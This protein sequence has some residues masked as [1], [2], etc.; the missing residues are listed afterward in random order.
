MQLKEEDAINE[1]EQTEVFNNA[2]NETWISGDNDDN[3]TDKED[4]DLNNVHH[5]CKEKNKKAF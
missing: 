4:D 5:K 2:M 3:D 1:N